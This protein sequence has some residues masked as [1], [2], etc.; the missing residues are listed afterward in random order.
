MYMKTTSNE[1][2]CGW[3]TVGGAVFCGLLAMGLTGCESAGYKKGG[4]AATSMQQAA[5]EVQAE[6]NA[7]D[8]AVRALNELYGDAGGDLRLS[9]QHYSAAVG[10]LESAARKT[11]ATGQR[12]ARRNAV[13]LTAW[14][15]NLQTIGYDHI[16]EIS[17]TRKGEVSGRFASVRQRY[18]ESQQ[19]VEPLI[20]YFRDIRAALATDLT[21]GGMESMKE[22][23]Q[24]AEQNAVKVQ[25]ALAAL[26]DELTASGAKLSA[27][28]PQQESTAAR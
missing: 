15:K 11:E 3:F 18:E 27:I 5:A 12:M 26:Q 9:F 28:L 25:T 4:A 24:N 20:R 23:V 14:D 10:R 8:L 13:Y 7:V 16:R 17:E 1:S 22:I 21:S 19:V 2:K 6:S